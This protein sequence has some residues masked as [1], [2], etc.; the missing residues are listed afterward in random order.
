MAYTK[1]KELTAKLA[2]ANSIIRAQ[3][4]TIKTLE[5]IKSVQASKIE[6]LKKRVTVNVD[7]V[8]SVMQTE[9]DKVNVKLHNSQTELAFF[10]TENINSIAKLENSFVALRDISSHTAELEIN[11]KAAELLIASL[12]EAQEEILKDKK[13][14]WRESKQLR[15]ELSTKTLRIRDLEKTIDIVDRLTTP[16]ITRTCNNG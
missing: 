11:L 3:N 7:L 8:R 10:K 16:S 6:A 9:L 12:R 5:T 14:Y 2:K 15:A 4:T 13:Y 1:N